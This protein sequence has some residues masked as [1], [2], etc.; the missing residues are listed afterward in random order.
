MVETTILNPQY[1]YVQATTPSDLTQGKL[2]YNTTAKAL[3]SSD[4]SSYS[5][6]TTDLTPLEAVDLILQK[7]NLEQGINI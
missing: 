3:Y 4:G 7:Q 6:M 2:W 1:V 5:T